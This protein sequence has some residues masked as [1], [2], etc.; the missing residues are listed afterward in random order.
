PYKALVDIGKAYS[1]AEIQQMLKAGKFDLSG[2]KI[3]S[4]EMG[5]SPGYTE[6]TKKAAVLWLLQKTG[7]KPQ[8]LT[9]N[10]FLNNGL[11]LGAFGDRRYNT[12]LAAGKAYSEKEIQQ[13]LKTGEFDFSGEKVYPWE[14]EISSI[15]TNLTKKAATLWLLQKTGKKSQEI[16]ANDFLGNGLVGLLSNIY[17]G[18]PYKAL[19]DA[20]KA[21]SEAEIQQMLN[22]G[23]FDFSGKKVYPWQMK[24]PPAIFDKQLMK[25]AEQKYKKAREKLVGGPPYRPE[26]IKFYP[27]IPGKEKPLKMSAGAKIP[28]YSLLPK[29]KS[30]IFEQKVKH[31]AIF[32]LDTYYIIDLMVSGKNI[33]STLKRLKEA[34]KDGEV[35]IPKQVLRELELQTLNRRT[36]G[37]GNKYGVDPKT[38]LVPPQLLQEFQEAIYADN[39]VQIENTSVSPQLMA[40]LKQILKKGS[41]EKGSSRVGIGDAGIYS[42]L[43]EFGILY[44]K[45]G[46]SLYILSQDK[47]IPILVKHLN[48][49]ENINTKVSF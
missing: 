6:L 38:L 14:M 42:F 25:E 9:Q 26:I 7:K 4:W 43:K 24:N 39:S 34:S 48:K 45:D 27:K 3:Y 28:A 44:E 22:T 46:C 40:E 15:Y 35:I 36:H 29:S 5:Y 19:V 16:T 47:H 21:Y 30:K 8:E 20:G 32:V 33:R 49:T 12:L 11:L 10:D 2:K 18:S 17:S 41:E 13:M 1:E 31:P 37:E 23:R